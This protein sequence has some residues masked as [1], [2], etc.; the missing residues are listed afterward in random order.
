MNENTNYEALENMQDYQMNAQAKVPVRLE[1]IWLDGNSPKTI[2]SKVRFDNW[3]LDSQ[4]GNI[5]QK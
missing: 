5:L 1:Y 3:T 4:S 2:R